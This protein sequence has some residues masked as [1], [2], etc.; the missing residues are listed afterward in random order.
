M[1]RRETP[2]FSTTSNDHA[3]QAAKRYKLK[4]TET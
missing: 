1:G 3:A 4:L 2:L